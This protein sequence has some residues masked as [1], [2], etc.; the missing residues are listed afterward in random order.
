M[1][2][3]RTNCEMACKA[4]LEQPGGVTQLQAHTDL[5]ALDIDFAQATGADRVLI[6]MGIGVLAQR[7]FDCFAGNKAHD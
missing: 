7:G 6:Q 4:I 2:I 5:A 3:A 1:P